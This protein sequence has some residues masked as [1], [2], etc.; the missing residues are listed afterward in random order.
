MCKLATCLLF[1]LLSFATHAYAGNETGTVRFTHGQ[2]FST[3]VHPGYT[4]FF[5]EGEVK[6]SKPPC[7]THENGERWV[8][9]NAWPAAKAQMAVLLSAKL[10]GK[11]VWVYGTNDCA[12]WSDSETV[13]DV[14]I[15]D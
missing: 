14:F 6:N 8:I 11:R 5:L 1:F 7:A 10:A 4:F 2:I 9:N 13:W 15:V 3:A 12:V